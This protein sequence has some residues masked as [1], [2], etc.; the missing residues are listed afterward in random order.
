M[1]DRLKGALVEVDTRTGYIRGIYISCSDDRE[2]QVIRGAVARITDRR[3]W[4]WLR[5]LMG[6]GGGGW[7]RE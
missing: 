6:K 7:H 5:R 1:R 2:A 4:R 3:A